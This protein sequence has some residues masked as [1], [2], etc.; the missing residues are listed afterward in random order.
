MNSLYGTPTNLVLTRKLTPSAKQR[1]K[2]LIASVTNDTKQGK[3]KNT[4]LNTPSKGNT[5]VFGCFGG[6]DDTYSKSISRRSGNDD[7]SQTNSSATV[8]SVSDE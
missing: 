8:N 7:S 6:D 2:Q 3:K 1:R 5:V 4:K